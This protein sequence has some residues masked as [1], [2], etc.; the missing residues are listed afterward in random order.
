MK[1]LAMFDLDKTIFD[2]HSLFAIV[3]DL[4]SN[5]LIE[6]SAKTEVYGFLNNCITGELSYSEAAG[7]MLV[8]CAKSLKGK[9][10]SQV[11]TSIKNMFI[12]DQN[13]FYP[14]FAKILPILL[15][16]HDVY[17]V[18]TNAQ[19]VAQIVQEMFGITGYISSEFEVVDGIFTGEVT[20]S[21]ANGKSAAQ[22]LLNKYGKAGSLAVGDSK[23]DVGMLELVEFPICINP[24]EELKQHA[25][26][27]N[28][29]VTTD[30]EIERLIFTFLNSANF[31]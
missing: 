6:S 1:K 19:F 16:T 21:L 23:N 8:S 7:K 29:Q 26:Q 2:S 28:W 11:K 30:T 4:I 5:N 13:H 12:R 18:T 20:Q 3:D 25:L 27:N 15:K 9:T 22:D 24:D 17:L 14:Y 31:Q 10:D